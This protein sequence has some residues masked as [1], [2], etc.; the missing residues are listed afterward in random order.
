M[1]A[2]AGSSE[3]R[4]STASSTESL[5]KAGTVQRYGACF[6]CQ[7]RN[8]PVPWERAGVDGTAAVS[9]LTRRK[10]AP[11]WLDICAKRIKNTL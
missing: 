10:L 7:K 3:S 8:S 1:R 11:A 5:Q 4:Q 2:S 9:Y 6:V